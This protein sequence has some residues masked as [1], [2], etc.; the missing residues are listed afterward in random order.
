VA[1]WSRG[2]VIEVLGVSMW[3]RG[4]ARHDH[5]LAAGALVALL[6]CDYSMV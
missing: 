5:D 1:L 4:A 2:G 6:W 3:A